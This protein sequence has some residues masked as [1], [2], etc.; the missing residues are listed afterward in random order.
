MSLI[1]DHL[2]NFILK[3]AYFTRNEYNDMPSS[4]KNELYLYMLRK[5]DTELGRNVKYTEGNIEYS[6]RDAITNNIDITQ[7]TPQNK[8]YA[9]Q[10]ITNSS[11]YIDILSLLNP[12]SEQLSEYINDTFYFSDYFKNFSMDV[13]ELYYYGGVKIPSFLQQYISEER[14]KLDQN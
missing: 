10:I 1:Q 11:Q 13:L 5:L 3:W 12:T 6:V 7:L 4:I 14:P 9:E 8:T 2:R